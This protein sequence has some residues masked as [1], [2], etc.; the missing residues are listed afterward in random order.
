MTTDLLVASLQALGR[1]EVAAAETLAVAAAEQGSMLGRVLAGYL[2]KQAGASVYAQPEAFE[3]FIRGGGNVP[4][5]QRVSDA[6]ASLY[7]EFGVDALLD[8]GCGD[9]L[10]LLPALQRTRHLPRRIDLVEPSHALLQVALRDL[11]AAILQPVPHC[12][13]WPMTAQAFVAR[14]AEGGHWSMAQA[15]F[16]LQALPPAERESVLHQ[17]RPHVGMLAVIEFDV[18]QREPDHAA[19]LASLVRR[20]EIGVAEY[21]EA[22]DLV[23][24]GFLAPMLAGQAGASAEPGNWEQ[25][26]AGWRRQLQQAGFTPVREVPL[27]DY[28]WSPAVLM[29]AT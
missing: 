18:P 1:D 27:F 15:S 12:T 19:H 16:S 7:A 2:A 10:A 4:L 29:L 22:A 14:L 8:I 3:A 13:P 9:G 6:L 25:P 21:Q 11:A 24:T 26:V 23:G 17:L 20:Y 28:W 5:Y